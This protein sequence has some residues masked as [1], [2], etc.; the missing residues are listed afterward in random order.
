MLTRSVWRGW[1]REIGR[2]GIRRRVHAARHL[3][4]VADVLEARALLSAVTVTTLAD[5]LTAGDGQVTLREAL[6]AANTNASVDGSTAGESGVQD[7]IRFS[8]GLTGTI[9]LD[10]ALGQLQITDSVRIVGHSA[11]DTIIDAQR[12]SRVFDVAS[13]AGDVAFDGVT[14]TG[15][16]TTGDAS[17]GAGIRFLST[18]TL[19][20][21]GTAVSGNSTDGFTSFGAGIYTNV[22]AVVAVNSLISGNATLGRSSDG[23]GIFSQ[24]GPVSLTNSTLSGNTTSGYHSDGVAIYTVGGLATVSL[25][26][27]TV[28][29]N[30]AIGT[31]D[32]GS[33]GVAV[34]R[35]AVTVNN[36]I[37]T[38]NFN[39]D[40]SE[41]DLWISGYANPQTFSASHSILGATSEVPIDPA[42]VSS[43]DANGNLVGT[44]ANPIDAKLSPLADNGGATMTHALYA[45]SP[46]IDAGDNALAVDPSSAALTTDQ[47]GAGFPRIDHGT[48]DMGSYEGTF[49]SYSTPPINFP[50]VVTVADDELDSDLS[51]PSDLSLR[52]AIELANNSPGIDTITFDV[53]L[54]DVPL[55]LHLGRLI[56]ADTIRI[57]GL[58]AKHTMIDA[59]QASRVFDVLQGAGDVEFDGVTITGGKTT[60]NSY[61]GAGIQFLSSGTLT[62][63]GSV[64]SNNKTTGDLSRGGGIYTNSG[65][66]QVIDSLIVGNA[67]TGLGSTGSGIFSQ[68]APINITNSTLSGNLNSGLSAGATVYTIGGLGSVTLTNSTVTANFGIGP[69]HGGGGGISVVAGN[70]RL[71]NSILA[72]NFERNGSEYDIDIAGLASPGRFTSSHSII[73]T[74]AGNPLLPAPLGSPDVNGNLVGTQVNPIDARL[75]PLA[76]NGGATLTHAP[77]SDSPAIDAGDNALALDPS[78]AP[79]A[80]DQRGTGFPRINH[81]TVDAGSYEGSFGSYPS[82]VVNTPLVVTTANDELDSDLSDSNDLSLRE[83]IE[84]A[85]TTFGFDTISFAPALSGATFN[86]ALGQ[87]TILDDLKIVG[88]GASLTTINA[89]QLSRVIDIARTGVDLTLDGVTVT[90]GKTTADQDN[91]AGVR[92]RWAGTLTLN[93]SVVTGNTTI[94]NRALGAG[95]YAYG[96]SV[97]VV[98]S[99]VS[100]NSTSGVDSD[101]AGITSWNASINLTNSTI[102]GNT[103]SGF[104]AGAAAIYAAR[105]SANI[106][107]TNSTVTNN[108]G[109][110]DALG[111]GIYLF[112][113]WIHV[114]NS[115][116]S[117]NFSPTDGEYDIGLPGYASP[118]L[119]TASH[120]IIGANNGNS[121]VPTGSNN[122]D[123]NGNLIGTAG[124]P[125]DARLA[126]LADNGGATMTHALFAGS[127]AIDAGDNALA[128]G[129]DGSALA[130]DQR[131]AGF[132]R[133]DHSVVD[134]GGFEGHFPDFPDE[135]S[136]PPIVVTTSNDELD[137]DLSNLSDLSL[138]E[139]IEIANRT[140]GLDTIVFAPGLSGMTFYLTLGQLTVLDDLK[141][142]GLGASQT[143]IDAQQQSRVIDIPQSGG[144][145]TL[146]GLTVTGGK[147][148]TNQDHGGGIRMRWAG[149]LTLNQSIV[150]GNSTVG[151]NSYGGGI[152]A[153]GGSVI[154]VNSL[155]SGNSTIGSGSD[156]GAIFSRNSAISLTNSTLAGNTTSGF[157]SGGAAMYTLGRE[158]T[159]TLTNSTVSGNNGIGP[160]DE[161]G[162]GVVSI[163]AAIRIVNSI[164]SGNYNDD[165]TQYDIGISGYANPATFSATHSIIGVNTGNPL[166]PAPVGRPDANGNF[167]GTQAHPID[168]LLGPLSDNGGATPTFF[169][170]QGS[171][172]I[173]AGDNPLAVAPDGSLL[174]TDERGS[175]FP[176]IDHLIVDIGSFEGRYPDYPPKVSRRT[177]VVTTANDELDTDLSDPNDLSLREAIEIANNSFGLDTITFAPGLSG[178]TFQ[179]TLG[180][181]TILDDLKIVGLGAVNTVFDAQ[182]QSRVFDIPRSLVDL[183]LEDLTVTGGKTSGLA[184]VGGG[185]RIGRAG[186]LTLTRSIVSGNSTTGNN[187]YGGGIYAYG[188]QVN[189]LDSLISGNS[190]TGRGGDGGAIFSWNSVLNLTNSTLSG[191]RTSGYHAGGAAIY[192]FHGEST[193]TLTNS[194][195]TDNSGIGTEA[196]AGGGIVALRGR[197]TIHNSIITGNF[198]N[199]GSEFDIGISGYANPASVTASHSIIGVNAGNPF[200]PAP[201]GS[202]DANGNFIGTQADPINAKLAPLADNGGATMTHALLD[203]SP[204]INAGD[205]A[206]AVDPAGNPLLY[207]QRGPGFDRIIGGTVDMGAF[208]S[209]AVPDTPAFPRDEPIEGYYFDGNGLAKVLSDG[210]QLTI[211]DSNGNVWQGT[212]PTQ[213]LRIAAL[214]ISSTPTPVSYDP[215]TGA[216]TF[217]DGSV[218]NKVVNLAG[219]WLN[220]SAQETGVCQLGADLTFTN[221]LGQSS[222]G[223][224]LSAAQVIAT[225]WGNIVGTLTN[226]GQRIEWSNGKV[227]DLIPDLEANWTNASHQPTRVEQ[228]GSQ[229]VFVNRIGQTSPGRLLDATH[230]VATGWGNM[231]GTLVNGT[232]E[233]A[234]GTVWTQLPAASSDVDLAGLWDVSG[235]DTRVLQAGQTLTFVNR[236]GG[237]STGHFLTSTTVVATDWNVRGTISGNLLLWSNGTVWTR[238]PELGGAWIDAAGRE[239]GINQLERSLTFTDAQGRVTQGTLVGPNRVIESA[240]RRTGTFA[241]DVLTWSDGKVWSQIADLRGAW[242]TETGGAPTYVTQ[243][244]LSLLMISDTGGVGRGKFI[245]GKVASLVFDGAP[246]VAVNIEIPGKSSLVFANGWNW[247]RQA[248]GSL[249]DVFADPNLWPFA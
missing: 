63:T 99:L 245:A 237:T 135:V 10:P 101:G 155:I 223:R 122:P 75:A 110:A 162:G 147:T 19:T 98:D 137:S 33:G 176:R 230:V 51:D 11:K 194:T 82:P 18:G 43:P 42:P 59:R 198:N 161:S 183:T 220:A 4:V 49:G 121:L 200:N 172:A 60:G 39:R 221:V 116:V 89:Q 46:A 166:T 199:D 249:D 12:G 35:A 9:Q 206:L 167:I 118:S 202:P 233:W 246:T 130:H 27:T 150:S 3:P 169:L 214:S 57:E 104:Q 84:I 71:N 131:G 226:G 152:Y 37:L 34:V 134:V 248:A 76:D 103:Q 106:T 29:R 178:V 55:E 120:S 164:V 229:L 136:H 25:T 2:T 22:G 61:P 78:G 17:R 105:H 40:G 8:D 157:H 177:L 189:V 151:N 91:G 174:A 138:R 48:V 86:L 146:T 156:G 108:Y 242:T 52:E 85:N 158:G 102:S 56:I 180:Q 173:D 145:L 228:L 181:L 74:N 224:F 128:V 112:R 234:N 208:E 193:I 175:G 209:S 6:A 216:L 20:L 113:G 30:D 109:V 182:Q 28:T 213:T 65:P 197:V 80:N 64:V 203:D 187:S 41:R 212:L 90:G 232:I 196:E 7:E 244:G 68:N 47:R 227:W 144:D 148:S 127:P 160:G 23:A 53:S 170:Y 163:R 205:N 21:T 215:V 24:N 190:T 88:L 66:V 13:T 132:P 95:I 168:P 243:S 218:W 126:P 186:T 15:G 115:I 241:G 1:W 195:V 123:A 141:I 171:P 219:R 165:D 238:L 204:A 72:G 247:E 231:L 94:G 139:A 119:V 45:G 96:G 129:P 210:N 81:G 58:G 240:S 31:E 125:I 87:L 236:A 14:I 92:M 5:N 159:V 154:A 222:S 107:L 201:V 73:G 225:D 207:D 97:V 140:P 191:N 69:L 184:E 83:A 117:G 185:I 26:N 93:Q 217:S 16:K 143:I 142:V 153:F 179:L 211:I 114:N 192:T 54:K 67:T 38:G 188:G 77:L 70:V 50:L 111:G 32:G 235:Q 133:I 124:Q 36:S 44:Q 149:T 62:L 100:A 79:L 239:S